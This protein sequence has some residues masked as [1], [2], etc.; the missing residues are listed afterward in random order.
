MPSLESLITFVTAS[1]L[2]G[3]APGPDNLFVLTQSALY[4]RKAGWLIVLGLCTGLIVHTSAVALGVAAVLAASTFAFTVLK[5]LGAAYLLY[6]A[7]Q[8]F[9]A[10]PVSVAGHSASTLSGRRLYG[11][12]I[13]MN[14]TNPK[15]LVFFLAF[16]PQFAEPQ[17]GAVAPQILL[18]GVLFI[19]V[20]LIVFGGI[21]LVAGWLGEWLARSPHMQQWL[22]RLAGMVLAALALNLVL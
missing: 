19:G 18:L 4:G 5:V 7:W 12:G 3:L 16:L 6:L 8:A 21:A 15:V 17:Q 9:R 13:L 10:E 1:T 11:R 14:L 2:L 22:N 20:T